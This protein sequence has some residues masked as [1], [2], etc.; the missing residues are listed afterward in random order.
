[1]QLCLFVL[2]LS[3]S[4]CFPF[5]RKKQQ[6]LSLLISRV[7]SFLFSSEKN[8]FVF[9]LAL[10]KEKSNSNFLYLF[11]LF[12]CFP[13]DDKWWQVGRW[14]GIINLVLTWWLGWV[15]VTKWSKCWWCHI[16]MVPKLWKKFETKN[17]WL[18]CEVHKKNGKKK[19]N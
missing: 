13:N 12:F 6:L 14:C 9:C 4:K 16:E 1:M 2:F 11:L 18:S 3:C 10:N 8:K 15:V 7:F 17:E 5:G 19:K